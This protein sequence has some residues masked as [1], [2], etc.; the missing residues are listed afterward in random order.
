MTPVLFRS[1]DIGNWIGFLR[2]SLG[3]F[4]K[5]RITEL[6]ANK[7]SLSVFCP[8]R[9][10][11]CVAEDD[12]CFFAGAA[13][14][15]SNRCSNSYDSLIVFNQIEFFIYGRCQLPGRRDLNLYD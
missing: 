2:G 8:N 11:R 6:L 5:K 1:M 3:C 9:C 14:V 10:H 15:Y 7:Q 13:L 4:G 12:S